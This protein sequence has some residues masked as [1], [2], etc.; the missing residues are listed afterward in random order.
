[1]TDLVETI[2]N[3]SDLSGTRCLIRVNTRYVKMKECK[4]VKKDSP[5]TTVERSGF[6]R[7]SLHDMVVAKLPAEYPI[8]VLR[9]TDNQS[10]KN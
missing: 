2:G 9:P 6:R 7:I 5:V 10:T 1:M 3:Q 4:N 8:T